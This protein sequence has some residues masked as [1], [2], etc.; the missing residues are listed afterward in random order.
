M[1]VLLLEVVDVKALRLMSL[2][3]L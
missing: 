2:H 3:C 1:I